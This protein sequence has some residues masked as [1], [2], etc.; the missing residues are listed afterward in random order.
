MMQIAS[1]AGAPKYL[2]KTPKFIRRYKF[3]NYIREEASYL[4]E[5]G[6]ETGINRK[7]RDADEHFLGA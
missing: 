7:R 6:D 1:R 4:C 2:R 5:F 3:I